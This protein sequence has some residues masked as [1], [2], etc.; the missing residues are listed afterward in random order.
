MRNKIFLLLTAMTAVVLLVFMGCQNS[1]EDSAGNLPF[2]ETT[3]TGGTAE[4]LKGEEA[5]YSLDAY[6][7]IMSISY[8]DWTE[9]DEIPATGIYLVDTDHVPFNLDEMLAEDD[10]I[11]NEDGTL[12]DCDGNLQTLFMFS[13]SIKV[14]S[15]KSADIKG[16]P[17]VFSYYTWSMRWKYDGGYC[18]DYYAWTDAYAWGPELGGGRPRT[19]IEYIYTYASIGSLSDNDH[20]YNCDEEHSKAH[21]HVGCF[22][23]AHE[24]PCGYHYAYWRDGSITGTHDWSWCK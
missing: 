17:Y 21:W 15:D 1:V 19:K 7:Q 23:P 13:Q 8:S 3:I 22:W 10:L 2:V 11:L 12:V 16:D 9:M 18:R 5:G 14:I 24:P 6:P 20:C 4:I